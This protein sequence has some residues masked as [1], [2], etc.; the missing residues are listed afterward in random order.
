MF[1]WRRRNPSPPI[2][3]GL[4]ACQKYSNQ[5][6]KKFTKN[7]QEG[8]IHQQTLLRAAGR[9]G[10]GAG[11]EVGVLHSPINHRAVLGGLAGQLLGAEAQKRVRRGE[12]KKPVTGSAGKWGGTEKPQEGKT[13]RYTERLDKLNE[14]VGKGGRRR[15]QEEGKESKDS[16][17]E[18]AAPLTRHVPRLP[19]PSAAETFPQTAG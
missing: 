15:Q 3:A 6:K 13:K 18:A 2:A 19:P 7:T 17:R 11:S 9:G 14:N 16:E 12:L 1:H 10:R 5:N 8:D 4:S